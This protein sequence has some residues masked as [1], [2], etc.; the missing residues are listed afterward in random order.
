MD[1]IPFLAHSASPVLLANISDQT[2]DVNYQ[3]GTKFSI[4][5]LYKEDL[6]IIVEPYSIQKKDTLSLFKS[7]SYLSIKPE[8]FWQFGVFLEKSAELHP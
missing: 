2:F 1:G 7:P 3:G 5:G 4:T 6:V 8:M